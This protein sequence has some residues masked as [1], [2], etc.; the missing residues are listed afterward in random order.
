MRGKIV[1]RAKFICPSCSAS[2]RYL[3]YTLKS[4]LHIPGTPD[5]R[6]RLE[7]VNCGADFADSLSHLKTDVRPR[8][9]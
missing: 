4:G 7:C 8:I 5:C 6:K 9:G 3:F 1:E 2:I